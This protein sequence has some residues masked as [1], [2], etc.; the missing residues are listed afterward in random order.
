[1]AGS[2]ECC[3]RPFDSIKDRG[4]SDHLS[5][6][7]SGNTLLHTVSYLKCMFIYG[8]KLENGTSSK[9]LT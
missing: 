5:V 3:N 6:S 2:H 9:C 8:H 7:L 1:M 4:F